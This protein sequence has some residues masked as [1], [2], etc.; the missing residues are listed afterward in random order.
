[1]H[2]SEN[3]HMGFLNFSYLTFPLLYILIKRADTSKKSKFDIIGGKVGS[4][5][6]EWTGLSN[7]HPGR[8]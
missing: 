5:I 8:S 7:Q 3:V 6:R 4:D 1:M 2:V